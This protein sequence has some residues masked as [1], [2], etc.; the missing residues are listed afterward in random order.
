MWNS[1]APFDHLP[2]ELGEVGHLDRDGRQAGAS[3][4][5]RQ[6]AAIGRTA[7]RPASAGVEPG[8]RLGVVGGEGGILVRSGRRRPGGQGAGR[9]RCARMQKVA[10]RLRFAHGVA[11]I[12]RERRTGSEVQ[13]VR[14]NQSTRRADAMRKFGSRP[15]RLPLLT[16]HQK[17]RHVA[18]SKPPAS[19]ATWL[20]WGTA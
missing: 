1:F 16:P 18:Y 5:A 8:E 13:S 2:R 12:D 17:A 15:T 9:R 7:D 4:P 3:K 10:P 20:R 19:L 11:S 6:P 14:I